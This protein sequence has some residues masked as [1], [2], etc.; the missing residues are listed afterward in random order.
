[1]K[2]KISI[3]GQWPERVISCPTLRHEKSTRL[4][5]V[6]ESLL[7]T[8]HQAGEAR[9]HLQ[10]MAH[11]ELRTSSQDRGSTRKEEGAQLS[12]FHFINVAVI[13]HRPVRNAEGRRVRAR[14]THERFFSAESETFEDLQYMSEL[15][16]HLIGFC[17]LS[18]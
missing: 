7:R 13:Q 10:A 18:R 6:P 2:I 12:I 4:Q 17:L 5:Y 8:D 11:K 1:V 3:F 14:P 15:S 9:S 16:G